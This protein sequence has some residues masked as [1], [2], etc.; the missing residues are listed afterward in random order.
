MYSNANSAE[1]GANHWSAL[2]PMVYVRR[3]RKGTD[4]S[5]TIASYTSLHSDAAW[6]GAPV[7]FSVQRPL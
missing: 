1:I 3:N 7:S 4:L 2:C 6:I 5:R